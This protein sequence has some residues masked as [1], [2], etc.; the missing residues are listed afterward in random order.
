MAKMNIRR[1]VEK[2]LDRDV[3]VKKGLARGII[4]VRAL[5]REI[6]EKLGHEASLYAIINAIRRYP[7]EEK[8]EEVPKKFFKNCRISVK[9]KIAD[10]AIVNNSEAQIKLGEVFSLIDL[11]SGA[12]LRII[13][14]VKSIK[15]ILDEDNVEKVE[16]LFQKSMI[17]K[18]RRNLSEVVISFPEKIEELKI[19][20]AVGVA[21]KITSEL[22]LNG[23]NII[24][25]MTAAPDFILIVNERDAVKSYEILQ[26]L[27]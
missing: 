25:L 23:I 22:A 4:N 2:L 17:I 26:K 10:M 16:S 18:I 9:N 19:E 8:V 15:L 14:A 27:V 1:E 7:I 13:V 21:S 6:Q 20:E 24:E 3:I 11:G 12:T 5:A